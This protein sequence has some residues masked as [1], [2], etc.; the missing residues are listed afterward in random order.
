[1]SAVETLLNDVERRDGKRLRWQTLRVAWELVP[2]SDPR[3]KHILGHN[4]EE[5]QWI[6]RMFSTVCS[7]LAVFVA[8]E[9]FTNEYEKPGS[10]KVRQWIRRREERGYFNN[11][12]RELA[13]EDTAE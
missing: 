10:G 3:A 7:L 12:V 6:T 8:L 5:T 4:F 2:A 9:V 13:I 1:M 11:I